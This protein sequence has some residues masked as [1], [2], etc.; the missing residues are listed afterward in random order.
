MRVAPIC[1]ISVE[2]YYRFLSSK[3]HYRT[4]VTQKHV[5]DTEQVAESGVW[6][7]CPEARRPRGDPRMQAG[8]D[9][10]QVPP[11]RGCAP[12]GG[13]PG[14]HPDTPWNRPSPWRHRESDSPRGTVRL[15][16]VAARRP[17]RQSLGLCLMAIVPSQDGGVPLPLCEEDRR[18]EFCSAGISQLLLAQPVL[19]PEM[20][21]NGTLLYIDPR[22]V[23][24]P[25][26]WDTGHTR[27]QSRREG[28]TRGR[29]T[30][31]GSP[32]TGG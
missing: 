22:D 1:E 31:S 24:G 29:R 12:Q 13:S 21:T 5:K 18:T 14:G 9:K 26:G 25:A 4:L 20:Q 27:P 17:S 2:F 32:D 15:L 11:A 3:A 19:G 23:Q 6:L 16:R 10:P 30:G 8:G 7:S 28:L